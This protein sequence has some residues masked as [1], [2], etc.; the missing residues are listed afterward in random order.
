MREGQRAS[1]VKNIGSKALTPKG[2]TANMRLDLNNAVSLFPVRK[3]PPPKTVSLRQLPVGRCARI[4]RLLG[5]P[6]HIHRLEEF[7]LRRGTKIEM[8][9][10]GNPC[11]IR[12][13]GSKICIRAEDTLAV[14]VAPAG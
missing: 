14:L 12:L 5:C 1:V 9:R 11:I 13:A 6:D 4:P 10:A 7:G 8:F 2:R 3:K